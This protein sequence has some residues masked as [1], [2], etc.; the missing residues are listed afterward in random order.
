MANSRY[1]ERLL[2][3][4]SDFAVGY[5]FLPFL[6]GRDPPE[7]LGLFL[8]VTQLL[9][10]EMPTRFFSWV[11]LYASFLSTRLH[12]AQGRCPGGA[13]GAAAYM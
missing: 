13:L 9:H 4:H 6:G 5:F 3:L 10:R 1:M 11:A 8:L 2:M 7:G 12:C